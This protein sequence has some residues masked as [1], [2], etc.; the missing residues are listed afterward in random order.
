MIELLAATTNRGKLEEIK[1]LFVRSHVD[2]T[3][4]CLAD[5]N[6]TAQCPEDGQTFAENAAAKAIFYSLMV[7]G[8]FTVGDDSGLA[9]DILKGAPGVYS[10]RYSG[11]E[12]TDDKNTSKLLQ[13]LKDIPNRNAKFVTV[14][15]LA[16]DGNVIASFSGEVVG[17]IIDERRGDFGF[18]YDPVFYYPPL[19]KTFAQLT[20]VEKN[21]ISHRA[22]A[23]AQLKDY[24]KKL[25]TNYTGPV[26]HK[27]YHS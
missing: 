23:F 10:S 25:P 9:V 4:Y 22:R 8:M 5:F 26:S 16:K 13:Q 1:I 3:L 6:I 27:F 12:A 15:C 11:A 20:T 17:E 19:K 21:H 18:G 14:V 2:V 7:P 24:L